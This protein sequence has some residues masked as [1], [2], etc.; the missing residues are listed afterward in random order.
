MNIKFLIRRQFTIFDCI[1]YRV[2]RLFLQQSSPRMS[3]LSL[4]NEILIKNIFSCSYITINDLFQLMLSCRG[5]YNI[6]VDSN[7]LWKCKLYSRLFAFYYERI[8]HIFM[9]ILNCRWPITISNMQLN[10][11]LPWLFAKHNVQNDKVI[12]RNWVFSLKVAEEV[13]RAVLSM[14]SKCYPLGKSVLAVEKWCVNVNVECPIL[15]FSELELL[16]LIF[17]EEM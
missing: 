6:I 10:R 15:M 12:W 11:T 16:D 13:R 1:N 5:L 9:F 2:S 14:S 3:L 8:T 7:R 17:N 4:P